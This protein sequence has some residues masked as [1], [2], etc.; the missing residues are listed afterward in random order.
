MIWVMDVAP[1][2]PENFERPGDEAQVSEIR[3]R[4]KKYVHAV[5]V[6]V[7]GVNLACGAASRFEDL[8]HLRRRLS[9]VDC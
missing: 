6:P 8:P 1:L 4:V 7:S 5:P 9:L 3:R 2:N